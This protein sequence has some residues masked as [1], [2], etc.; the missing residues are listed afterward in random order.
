MRYSSAADTRFKQRHAIKG[1]CAL[2]GKDSPAPPKKQWPDTKGNF[3][4]VTSVKFSDLGIADPILRA[5]SAAE[6][7]TPTPIQQK[8]IPLLIDGRDLLGIAQTGTGKTAAF[9]IPVL[10][11][12]AALPKR[13][14]ANAPHA[15]VLAPTRELALQIAEGFRTYGKFLGLRQTVICGGVGQGPQV[16]ALARGVDILVATPGRLMDLM[17]QRHIKLDHLSCLVLDEADRMLDMG[18]IRDVNKIVA[19]CP[20]SRQS[21]LFSATMAPNIAQ[22]AAKIL[23]DPE[24]V[25]ITPRKVAVDRIEQTIYHIEAGQKRALLMRLLGNPQLNRVIVFTRTKRGANKVSEYLEKAGISSDAI[26]GNKS[27]GARQRALKLFKSGKIRVLVATDIAS[28]GIDVDDV[29]HVINFELPY[30]PES[31]VHR[32]GRTARAGASGTAYSFCDATERGQLRS[33]ERLIKRSLEVAEGY[34]KLGPDIAAKKP[35][36]GRGGRKPT[37]SSAAKSR[38]R[39]NAKTTRGSATGHDPLIR[40]ERGSTNKA[41][42]PAGA[43][44]DRP[45][46]KRRPSR[47]NTRAKAPGSKASRAA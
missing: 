1:A 18:F 3:T 28:R 47:R 23:K 36:R 22:L 19:A 25:E 46:R 44:K 11:H 40:Q 6:Y 33:I 26:H 32:I 43:A 21:L 13:A 42:A 5:L 17:G 10:Q 12:L 37:L 15:L 41:K 45:Q 9:A 31:Y 39:N 35:Q 24:R 16:K 20:Q 29:T 8:S 14:A 2:L 34:E 30:E 4:K 27:Q 38:G 7:N